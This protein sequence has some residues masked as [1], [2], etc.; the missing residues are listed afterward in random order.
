L[1][2][3]VDQQDLQEDSVVLHTPKNW[4]KFILRFNGILAA[5]AIVAVLMPQS[6]LVWCVSKVEPG[7]K[8]GLLVSYLARALSMFFVLV[9]FL[10]IEF[11]KDV[12]RYKTPIRIIP[13]WCLFAIFSFGIY[14]SKN[15]PY[16]TKQWFFWA[17]TIDGVCSLIMITAV[18]ALQSRIEN[19]NS[20][21]KEANKSLQ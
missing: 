19:A 21:K 9:G 18:L 1:I 5:L 12:E 16:V 11:A 14:A 7:L 3:N 4:L 13:I 15:L 10:L 20:P 8:V 2:L 17:I 6:W